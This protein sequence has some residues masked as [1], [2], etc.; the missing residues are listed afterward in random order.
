MPVLWHQAL[1]AL[2]QRYKSDLSSEQK[3]ALMDLIKT[4]YHD[5]ISPEIRRELTHAAPRDVEFASPDM[6]F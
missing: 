1:L 5:Q 6:D 2:A 3:D 4:H